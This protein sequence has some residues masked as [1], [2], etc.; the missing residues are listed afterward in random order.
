MAGSDQ[1]PAHARF[2]N[3][4]TALR[5]MSPLRGLTA[6]EN[7]L[8]DELMVQWNSGREITVG[9][10]MNGPKLGQ[11]GSTIHRRLLSLKG[12]GLVAFRASPNDKRIKYVEPTKLAACYAQELELR[13]REIG[14]G[15][16][17]T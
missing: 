10:I 16:S 8:L 14:L 7:L 11:A 9:S 2:L 15:V 1:S 5:R 6:D 12:K 13:L 4:I 17:N 3:V